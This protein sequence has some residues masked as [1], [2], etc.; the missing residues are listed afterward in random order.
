M[1]GILLNWSFKMKYEIDHNILESLLT[2]A[3][4]IEARDVYTGGH[5]WRVSQY[6]STITR[7]IG[8]SK[9]DI[10]L[11]SLGGMIHDIGK[12]GVPDAILNKKGPLD[13]HEYEII[14][15]HPK[16][17]NT[18]IEKHPLYDLVQM[19][20]NEHHERLDGKGYPSATTEQSIYGKI[21]SI[22]DAF[23]AMTST[24]SYRKGMSKEK[25]CELLSE[26]TETQFDKKLTEV[27]VTMSS[28]GD[29][30]SIIGHA[31]ENK[32]MLPCPHCGPIVV[33]PDSL[34]SGGEVVC[35][36]C[37]VHFVAHREMDSFDLEYTEKKSAVYIPK[38]D[39]DCIIHFMGNFPKK[40]MSNCKESCKVGKK[41]Y[42]SQHAE[43]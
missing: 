17:G 21:I 11:S 3:S 10:F 26:G 32:R 20:V 4:V 9:D 30:D 25:A 1:T 12:V 22:S 14:K 16:I 43:S 5:T 18:I 36:N 38:S 29:F 8:L 34:S 41:S 37:M 19:S 35:P 7:K 15:N 2:L 13:D 40:I 23:D 31:G 42:F 28:V 6:A 39:N 33:P 24:R 27:V